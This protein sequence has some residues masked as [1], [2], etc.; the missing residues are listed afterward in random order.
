MPELAHGE[1]EHL[2]EPWFEHDAPDSPAAKL[3]AKSPD[4]IFS[5][6]SQPLAVRRQDYIQRESP[7]SRALQLRSANVATEMERLVAYAE[8]R[9]DGVEAQRNRTAPDGRPL[10]DAPLRRL[11][12]PPI[13]AVPGHDRTS[14]RSSID[15]PTLP[16]LHIRRPWLVPRAAGV[17]L[18]R[19]CRGVRRLRAPVGGSGSVKGSGCRT[20]R[21]SKG[22][23]PHGMQLP[24]RRIARS[25]PSPTRWHRRREPSG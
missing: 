21:R 23:G 15:P 5:E 11:E 8:R 1:W 17:R 7:V 24:R 22:S 19:S 16:V 10:R 9:H 4:S 14:S 2:F 3:P 25:A 13:S 18:D 6:A 20:H 12:A